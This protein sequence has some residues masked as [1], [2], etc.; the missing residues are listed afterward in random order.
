MGLV[1]KITN[2]FFHPGRPKLSAV[3]L[4]IVNSS[5]VLFSLNCHSSSFPPTAVTWLHNGSVFSEG[6][7]MQVLRDASSTQF[8]N[9][10]YVFRSMGGTFTCQVANVKGNTSASITIDGM[11]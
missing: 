4:T 6:E 10:L 11:F 1:S 3:S 5:V 8:D 2:N 7:T 9:I